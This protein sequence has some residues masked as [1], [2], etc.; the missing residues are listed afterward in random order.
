MNTTKR[1]VAVRKT[2][3]KVIRSF[4]TRESARAFKRNTRGNI[5]LFDAVRQVNIR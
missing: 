2:T 4:T 3:G 5:G 1:W